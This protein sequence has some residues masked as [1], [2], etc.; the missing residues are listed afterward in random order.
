MTALARTDLPEINPVL[1][2]GAVDFINR[3]ARTSGLHLA[4]TVSEYVIDTFFGG[5]FAA[6]SSKDPHKTASFTA[7]CARE[8]LQMGPATLNRLVRIG[9]QARHLPSDLAESLSLSHHR[10]LL[11]VKAL[12]HKQHLAHE[13]AKHSWTVEQL[14]AQIAAEKPVVPNPLGRPHKAA[15]LKWLKAVQ[16]VT[17]KGV[18]AANWAYEVAELSPTDQAKLKADMQTLV[19]QLQLRLAALA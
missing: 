10:L 14:Q 11:S 9:Q 7:L 12:Q 3:A 1:L 8:D 19:A 4:V 5:D 15:A 16:T 18:D 2:D 6:I 13:A 17:T